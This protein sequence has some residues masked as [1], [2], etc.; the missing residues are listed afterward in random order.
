[1]GWEGPAPSCASLL[2]RTGSK[3]AISSVCPRGAILNPIFNTL[4]EQVSGET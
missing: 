3:A 2:L 1:M 4:Q